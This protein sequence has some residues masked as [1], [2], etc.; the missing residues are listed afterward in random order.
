MASSENS[1]K[2]PRKFRFGA[3]MD[4]ESQKGESRSIKDIG[5]CNVAREESSEA[6]SEFVGSSTAASSATSWAGLEVSESAG[7]AG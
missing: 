7:G 5:M 3:G 4:G 1:E 2:P 6:T